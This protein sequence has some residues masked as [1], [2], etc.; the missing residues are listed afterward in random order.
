MRVLLTLCLAALPVLAQA[1]AK[2]KAKAPAAKEAKAPAAKETKAATPAPAPAPKA[3]AFVG[4]KESKTFHK[5]ECRMAAKIKDANKVT[6]AAK[7]EADKAG[8]KAC[9]VC[10]P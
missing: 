1:P 6:F 4:H 7:A 5:A 2:D 8:F 3:T 10:K 9:K